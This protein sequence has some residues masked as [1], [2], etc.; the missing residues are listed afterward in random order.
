MEKDTD[1]ELVL[2]LL[3]LMAIATSIYPL[4]RVLYAHSTD[5]LSTLH[6][7]G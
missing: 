3:A 7:S 1:M 4:D 5:F 2:L 6:I